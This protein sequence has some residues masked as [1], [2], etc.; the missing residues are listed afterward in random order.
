MDKQHQTVLTCTVMES[1]LT[2]PTPKTTTWSMTGQLHDSL[3]PQ[4]EPLGPPGV[5]LKLTLRK[6]L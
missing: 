1:P 2:G 6:P 5:P 3:L 4:V